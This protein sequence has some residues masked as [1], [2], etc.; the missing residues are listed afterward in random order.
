MYFQV[1]I[2]A[3]KKIKAEEGTRKW[4]DAFFPKIGVGEALPM[5]AGGIWVEV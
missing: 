5:V 3:K 4:K 1:I 2:S